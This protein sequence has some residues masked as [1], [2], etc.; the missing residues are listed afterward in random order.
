LIGAASSGL[1]LELERTLA[2]GISASA[3]IGKRL[4][5]APRSP[6]SPTHNSKRNVQYLFSGLVD[7]YSLV[8]RLG[9]TSR[10]DVGNKALE[11]VALACG[12]GW[13][14]STALKLWAPP[15]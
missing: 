10:G 3:R 5:T 11:L 15:P 14:S 2:R 13:M 12:L 6:A 8:G 9:S 1:T 7:W 4:A